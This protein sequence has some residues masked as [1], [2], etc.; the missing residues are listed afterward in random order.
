MIFDLDPDEDLRWRDVVDASF[1]VRDAL[2]ALGLNSFVKTTG[3]K[4][5]HIVVPLIRRH[6]WDTVFRFS[7]AFV[8]GLSA[9]APQ[10]FTANMA[11]R[12]R[13]GRVFIDYHRNRRGST[14]VTAYS[15]RAR[16]GAPVSTPLSW[17][18]LRQIDDFRDLDWSSMPKRLIERHADPWQD[19]DEAAGC[20]TRELEAR[21]GI[22][23]PDKT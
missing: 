4:G 20:I 1:H 7:R 11:K 3:G 15:L 21:V 2:E 13:R 6:A 5:V 19:I 9:S 18:E 14:A 16:P 12:S 23:R 17:Q 10:R 8:E 22:K